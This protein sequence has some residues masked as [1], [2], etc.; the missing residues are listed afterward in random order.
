MACDTV[1][2]GSTLP[3]FRK[4][5][6]ASSFGVENGVILFYRNVVT[7]LPVYATVSCKKVNFCDFSFHSVVNKDN[8]LPGYDAV[9]IGD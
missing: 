2:F 6:I 9:F 8:S 5:Y 4:E 1:Q 3:S 7:M